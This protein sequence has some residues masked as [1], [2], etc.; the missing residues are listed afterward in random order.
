MFLERNCSPTDGHQYWNICYPHQEDHKLGY[1]HFQ[2][3]KEDCEEDTL[4]KDL[5][6]SI[7]YYLYLGLT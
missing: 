6:K 7:L 3:M 1:S 2:N 4:L 5:T